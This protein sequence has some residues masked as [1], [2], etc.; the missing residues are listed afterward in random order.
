[1]KTFFIIIM[2]FSPYCLAK[3]Q[4]ICLDYYDSYPYTLAIGNSSYYYLSDDTQNCSHNCDTNLNCKGFNFNFKNETLNCEIIF[5]V[6][7]TIYSPNCIFYQKSNWVCGNSEIVFMLIIFVTIFFFMFICY[8]V[9]P[10]K[11]RNFQRHSGYQ[12]IE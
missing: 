9:N 4:E 7:Y 2:L 5:N 8:F 11:D 12:S 10:C 6:I 3:S 1:M